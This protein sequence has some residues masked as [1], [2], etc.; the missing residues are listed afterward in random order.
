VSTPV[1]RQEAAVARVLFGLREAQGTSQATLAERMRAAGHSWH[2][3]TVWKVENGDRRV[4]LTEGVALARIYG[5]DMSVF[6]T[7]S[8]AVR[9]AEQRMAEAEEAAQEACRV[10]S[11]AHAAWSALIEANPDEAPWRQE[12]A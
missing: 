2:Q 7:T 10:A 5:V 6:D 9:H 8:E 3:A 1:E 4:S 12:T 11:R